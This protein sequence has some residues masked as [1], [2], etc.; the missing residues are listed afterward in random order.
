M[1]PKAERFRVLTMAV[2][3]TRQ[4]ALSDGTIRAAMPV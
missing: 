4:K 1:D 3:A 2:D